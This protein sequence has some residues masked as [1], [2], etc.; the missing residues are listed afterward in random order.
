MTWL[1]HTAIRFGDP[2]ENRDRIPVAFP[3]K[4][5]GAKVDGFVRRHDDRPAVRPTFDAA[6]VE[7]RDSKRAITWARS[8]S[9]RRAA[10]SSTSYRTLTHPMVKVVL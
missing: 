9:M 4:V 2:R 10:N 6:S 1:L 5:M 7:L 3:I 8:P